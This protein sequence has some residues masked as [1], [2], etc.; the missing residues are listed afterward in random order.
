M[1]HVTIPIHPSGP[2]PL[3]YYRYQFQLLVS[4]APKARPATLMFALDTSADCSVI[5]ER[6]L[7]KHGLRLQRVAPPAAWA[8]SPKLGRDWFAEFYF[9]FVPPRWS[10][11]GFQ[12]PVFFS[13]ECRV[14]SSGLSRG[15]LA[16]RDVFN[17]FAMSVGPHRELIL[18]L[19]PNHHG[20]PP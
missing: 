5:P 13:S 1:P 19:L 8:A 9:E 11:A 4:A 10:P 2:G 3:Y 7:T 12:A 6:L 20:Q 14:T 18:T 17:N 15:H 16:L